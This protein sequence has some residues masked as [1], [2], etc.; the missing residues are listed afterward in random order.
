MILYI[1]YIYII[2][3][4]RARVTLTQKAVEKKYNIYIYILTQYILDS[5]IN[6]QRP[7]NITG[8]LGK[9]SAKCANVVCC[10]LLCQAVNL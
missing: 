3:H 10:C 2:Y 1:I 5:W 6:N 7:S 8:M 4:V 9:L